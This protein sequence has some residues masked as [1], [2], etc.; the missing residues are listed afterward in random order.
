MLSNIATYRAAMTAQKCLPFT[1][2]LLWIIGDLKVKYV[3]LPP[4][5]CGKQKQNEA[6][7]WTIFH[8]VSFSRQTVD[9]SWINLE[10][11]ITV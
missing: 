2:L 7:H 4:E 1:F 11:E 9:K 10:S 3:L 8:Q 5:E 6:K